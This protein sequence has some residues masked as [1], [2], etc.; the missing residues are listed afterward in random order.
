MPKKAIFKK[1]QIRAKAF[2]MFEKN[3]LDDITARSLAK[4]LNCSPA[5]IYSSYTSMDELKLE[6]IEDAKKIFLD[7]VSSS[8]TDLIFL[9]K[10]IGLCAFAREEKELFKSIFLRNNSYGGLLKKF[11]NLIRD[12]MDKDERFTNLP[13]EFKYQLFLECWL[14]AHGLATLIATDYFAEP[15]NEFI[16]KTLMDSAAVMLYKKLD[17][18]KVNN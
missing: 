1:E 4:E 11:R 5:P 3:G 12:E 18:Y 14:V 13:L 16:K 10:G 6:L 15:T 2:E 8:E 9:N 17:D 7:Y